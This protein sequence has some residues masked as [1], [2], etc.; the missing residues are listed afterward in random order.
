MGAGVRGG[1]AAARVPL[2]HGGLT[3]ED[4]LQVLTVEPPRLGQGHDTLSV[5]GELLDVHFLG[6]VEKSRLRGLPHLKAHLI[7]HRH[8]KQ[9]LSLIPSQGK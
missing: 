1:G 3:A 4:N 9:D 2:L 5:V 7:I 6:D 8:A